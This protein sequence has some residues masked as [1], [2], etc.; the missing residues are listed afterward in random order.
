MRKPAVRITLLPELI[1]FDDQKVLGES[2]A[3]KQ[4]VLPQEAVE[5]IAKEAQIATHKALEKSITDE[6]AGAIGTSMVV[7]YIR[8]LCGKLEE[9]A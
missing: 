7:D 8:Y 3:F 4:W 9:G 2:V 1:Y 5:A 6:F